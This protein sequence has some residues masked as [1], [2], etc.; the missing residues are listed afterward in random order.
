[1]HCDF[2]YGVM[3]VYHH[4]AITTISSSSPPNEVASDHYIS[5]LQ[6]D[7]EI[8]LNQLC[9][10]QSSFSGLGRV[11]NVFAVCPKDH[12]NGVMNVKSVISYQ[13]HG[14]SITCFTC[15]QP[16]QPHEWLNQPPPSSFR[17]WAATTTILPAS[18]SLTPAAPPHPF[19]PRLASSRS[20]M[21]LQAVTAAQDLSMD[22]SWLART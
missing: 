1:M 11:M 6:N 9:S 2:V 16:S 15:N 7:F 5:S 13:Q 8:E 3:K 17:R 10:P 21:T 22:T 12:C 20:T 4:T 14:Q 19:Y 18:R